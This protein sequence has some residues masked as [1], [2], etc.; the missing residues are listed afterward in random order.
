MFT[1]GFTK[2]AVEKKIELFAKIYLQGFKY[3]PTFA[4]AFEQQLPKKLELEII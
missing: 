2:N 3:S 4:S 1:R